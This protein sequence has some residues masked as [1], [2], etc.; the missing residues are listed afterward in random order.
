MNAHYA[1]NSPAHAISRRNFLAGTAAAGIGM[2]GFKDAAFF[3]L[4]DVAERV[5]PQVQF[6]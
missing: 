4:D 3:T 6:P 2:L 5:V 1:C